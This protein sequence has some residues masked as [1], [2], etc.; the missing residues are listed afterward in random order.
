ML[1]RISAIHEEALKL[2]APEDT[3]PHAMSVATSAIGFSVHWH[4]MA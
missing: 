4:Q 3:N 1:N 2:V